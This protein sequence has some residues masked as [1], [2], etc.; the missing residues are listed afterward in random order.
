M[1]IV[2]TWP[3]EGIW[4]ASHRCFLIGPLFLSFPQ[5]ISSSVG[6]VWLT[7]EIYGFISWRRLWETWLFSQTNR[8]PDIR[9]T[10]YS[11]T[12][13]PPLTTF[14]ETSHRDPPHWRDR[15]KPLWPQWNVSWNRTMIWRNSYVKKT[16]DTMFKRKT[17]KT[18][19]NEGNQKGQRVVTH[20]A[21]QSGGTWAF[22]L[23]WIQL[24]HLLSQRCR[25]W[26]NKWMLWWML[27]R[28]EC[29]ATLTI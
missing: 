7:G 28:D 29:P 4:P 13:W 11:L 14:K 3:S 2:L 18:I 19:R 5:V 27:S 21:D 8:F 23:S 10:W 22:R 17:R 9:V 15:S 26:R 24:H 1:R 12:R 20:W 16:Q 6:I 25:R